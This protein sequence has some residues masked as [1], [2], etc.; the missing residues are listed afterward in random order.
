MILERRI[1]EAFAIVVT[2]DFFLHHSCE[3][4]NPLASASTTHPL[5]CESATKSQLEVVN[6]QQVHHALEILGV[7]RT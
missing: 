7:E 3:F 2:L 6:I 1:I 4:T 5:G